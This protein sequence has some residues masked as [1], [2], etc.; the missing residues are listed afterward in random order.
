MISDLKRNELPTLAM[1][2]SLLSSEVCSVFV[3]YLQDK[4]ADNTAQH[5]MI[6]LNFKFQ[7]F[8]PLSIVRYFMENGR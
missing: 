6:S 8:S 4:V 7:S 3:R 2:C 1:R 5:D